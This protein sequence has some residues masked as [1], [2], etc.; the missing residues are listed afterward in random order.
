MSSCQKAT[1]STAHVCL[2]VSPGSASNDQSL[3]GGGVINNL[4][5]T[6]NRFSPLIA[7]ASVEWIVAPI[8]LGSS[9][10]RIYSF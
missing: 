7:S 6:G 10:S 9:S 1:A 2:S 4:I 3:K 5:A 8:V